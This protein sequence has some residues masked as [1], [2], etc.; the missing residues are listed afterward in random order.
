LPFSRCE[1][2]QPNALE[3]VSFVFLRRCVS[4]LQFDGS[5]ALTLY[6]ASFKFA[7]S[8]LFAAWVVS[9]CSYVRAPDQD[10]GRE[11]Q[12][13]QDALSDVLRTLLANYYRHHSG[14]RQNAANAGRPSQT[15]PVSTESQ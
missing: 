14:R 2:R 7:R 6:P 3:L 5:R 10:S 11:I 9:T 4:G 8:S 12:M 13:S 1:L 15:S